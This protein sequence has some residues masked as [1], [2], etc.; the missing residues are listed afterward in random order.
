MLTAPLSKWIHS[1]GTQCEPNISW[2]IG[3]VS[4]VVIEILPLLPIS[5]MSKLPIVFVL[6]RSMLAHKFGI[7]RVSEQTPQ[8]IDDGEVPHHQSRNL[9]ERIIVYFFFFFARGF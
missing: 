9:F 5:W 7:L 1:I 2:F 4:M 6:I 3:K 8:S